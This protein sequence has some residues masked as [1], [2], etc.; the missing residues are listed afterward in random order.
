MASR[1]TRTGTS[2]PN[3][4]EQSES[5]NGRAR[6]RD[7]A[8]SDLPLTVSLQDDE[9]AQ[10]AHFDLFLQEDTNLPSSNFA[11]TSDTS[12]R[13][14]SSFVTPV[15]NPTAIHVETL[16]NEYPAY[17]RDSI[18]AVLSSCDGDLDA[19]RHMLNES[20]P[21]ST[22]SRRQASRQLSNTR[23]PALNASRSAN[24]QDADTSSDATL[25]MFLQ[26]QEA[27]V[28]SR[29]RRI[30]V[31]VPLHDEAMT[32]FISSLRE[33][34]VPA[35]KA[36]FAELV[37]PDSRETSGSFKYELRSLQVA[38]LSLPAD[39]VSVRPAA[40]NRSVLVSVVDAHLELEV[41]HWSYET[42]T[43]V[44][45]SDSGRA[46]AT[47]HGLSVAI[48]LVPRRAHSGGTRIR[49][50]QCDVTVDG[51]VR[52]KVQGAA[53]D[54][55]YNTIAM[56]FKPWVVSYVKDA[57]ADAVEHA[58]SV[59][60]RQLEIASRLDDRSTNDDVS[61]NRSSTARDSQPPVTTME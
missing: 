44:P 21:S 26:R 47:V 52:F 61:L 45:I 30:D 59:H 32:R 34:V 23:S 3:S 60:L 28:M 16:A 57:V 54:W 10:L 50:E 36:H 15:S 19:A 33:I 11:Q 25:A 20:T 1:Q 4:P 17:D 56:L 37:L 18:A 12:P 14:S 27:S 39:N 2:D 40:D 31:V 13:E 38:A 9:E 29:R 43:L 42:Q 58:L 46:R 22:G 55:A 49:I 6:D 8:T 5:P 48:R 7:A 53:A 51:V 24:N 41:G 35:L